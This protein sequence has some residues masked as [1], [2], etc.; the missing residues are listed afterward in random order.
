MYVDMKIP[1]PHKVKEILLNGKKEEF[2]IEAD[3]EK[4]YIVSYTNPPQLDP[5][6]TY[7]ITQRKEGKVKIIFESKEWEEKV[8][9]FYA[10]VRISESF[11][12]C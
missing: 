11:N 1:W 6:K 10:G 8:K 12:E 9:E 7:V 2:V 5:T 3:E 4:G